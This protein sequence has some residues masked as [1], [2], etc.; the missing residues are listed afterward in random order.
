[1]SVFVHMRFLIFAFFAISWQSATVS[2]QD[3]LTVDLVLKNQSGIGQAFERNGEVVFEYIRPRAEAP[4]MMPYYTKPAIDD[5]SKVLMAVSGDGSDAQRLFE[6][7]NQ[8]AYSFVSDTPFSPSGRYIGIQRA[9]AF[10][11][12]PGV[13]DRKR[14]D[15]QFFDA[16][17]SVRYSAVFKHR[18]TFFWLS[19]EGVLVLAEDEGWAENHSAIAKGPQAQSAAREA[20]WR[21]TVTSSVV[22]GGRY[23]VRANTSAER[24][25]IKINIRTGKKE[26]IWSARGLADE[27]LSLSPSRRFAFVSYNGSVAA[28]VGDEPSDRCQD[29]CHALIDIETSTITD[30]SKDYMIDR[31]FFAW[32]PGGNSLLVTA[33]P[34][35]APEKESGFYAFHGV[36]GDVVAFDAQGAV[37]S[38][39]SR[40]AYQGRLKWATWLSNNS[41]AF[42]AAVENGAIGWATV[43]IGEAPV[44]LGEAGI[45]WPERPVARSN[46]ELFFLIDGELIGVSHAKGMRHL[47]EATGPLSIQSTSTIARRQ[48]DLPPL[49]EVP[50]SQDDNAI[51]FFTEDGLLNTR[52][53]LNGESTQLRAATPAALLYTQNEPHHASRLRITYDADDNRADLWTYNTHL[54][55]ITVSPRPKRVDYLGTEGEWLYGWLFLP[56][57]AAW[58]DVSV[59]YPL[60]VSAYAGTRYPETSADGLLFANPPWDVSLVAPISVPILTAAGYAVLL[61]SIPLQPRGEASDPMSA[62]MP[63]INAALNAALETGQIDESRLALTGHSYGGYTALSVGVQSD[64]FDAIIAAAAPSNLIGIHGQFT[65]KNRFDAS[66]VE[67]SVTKD[68]WGQMRMGSAPWKSEDRYIRNSPLFHAENVETPILLIQGD[69]DYVHLQQAEEMFTALAEQEKDVQFIRYWGEGHVIDQPQNQ[70]DMWARIFNF[71]HGSGVTPGP[72]M[73]H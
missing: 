44:Q 7:D 47:T 69:L 36:S 38:D 29:R 45:G 68:P 35:V 33:R 2:A 70:R 63:S 71:L 16:I 19:D 25:L 57:G 31:F 26:L 13:F 37:Q 11:V 65:Q 15:A 56:V 30:L 53:H 24:R 58:N 48:G 4:K 42:P 3:R 39:I 23:A 6:Q 61:P 12:T 28:Q 14:G 72:K 1:M 22:G 34:R 67:N 54:A 43:K 9:R 8:A 64:R 62:I 21:G 46:G 51:L 41:I 60:V 73:V 50:F 18:R 32:S 55:C 10:R 20:A 52:F 49:E 27:T 59:K 40:H 5:G 17:A 66:A